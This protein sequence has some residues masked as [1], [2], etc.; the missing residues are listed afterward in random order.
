MKVPG[1]HTTG[2]STARLT[3][4]AFRPSDAEAFYRL[5]SDP[6]VVRYTGDPPC[7]SV[8][9]AE[10]GIRAYPDWERVGFGRWATVH[11]ADQRVIGFAGL[12]YLAEL[13]AVDL[14]YRFLPEYWG[15]GLATEASSAC[16]SSGFEKLG[17]DAIIGLV[18]PENTASVRV[19]QKVRMRKVGTERFDGLVADRYELRRADWSRNGFCR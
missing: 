8:A 1:D 16:V 3:L 13:D 6:D 18:L 5:N 15:R 2:P 9:A 4:R 12:K 7:P 19:L 11:R 10:A 14:G 17:L